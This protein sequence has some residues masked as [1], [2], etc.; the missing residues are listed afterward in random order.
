MH[1]PIILISLQSSQD[2]CLWKGKPKN[3]PTGPWS[4]PD[5]DWRVP[6][7]GNSLMS[8]ANPSFA[9]PSLVR[10]MLPSCPFPEGTWPWM[11]EPGEVEKLLPSNEM[12][13]G[14]PAL[15]KFQ[16][17]SSQRRVETETHGKCHTCTSTA[18]FWIW[19]INTSADHGK[20]ITGRV[21]RWW[22]HI[23]T[24]LQYWVRRPPRSLPAHST[25]TS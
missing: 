10:P 23:H 7:W 11:P 12:P 5:D 17:S 1:F 8:K 9:P 13:F 14:E 2:N 15:T 3:T 6:S 25:T 20:Q 24:L 21:V 4:P 19:E 16:A 18:K 22:C